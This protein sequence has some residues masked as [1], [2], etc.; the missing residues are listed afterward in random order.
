ML[1]P[2]QLFL[3]GI[4]ASL[5]AILLFVVPTRAQTEPLSDDHKAHIV[6]NCASAKA[7]LERLHRSDAVL[8]VNRGQLYE[9]ISTKLMARFN[10]RVALNRL[11]GTE[12]VAI[13]VDYERAL[14][15]F[16]RDYRTYEQQLSDVLRINCTNDPE[17]FYYGVLEARAARSTVNQDVWRLHVY[18]DEYQQAFNQFEIDYVTALEVVTL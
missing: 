11:D 10:S 2:K 6:A 18:I 3:Y 9:S 8:R 16:R 13:A 12:L 15:T 7:S 14:A 1:Q 17:A 5:F 4:A